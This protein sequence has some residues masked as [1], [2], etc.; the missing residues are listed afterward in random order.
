MTKELILQKYSAGDWYQDE[1]I[2]GFVMADGSIDVCVEYGSDVDFGLH[3][4]DVLNDLV[5][6]IIP[7]NL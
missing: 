6:T 3:F 2:G 5:I 4:D 1:Y 7:V